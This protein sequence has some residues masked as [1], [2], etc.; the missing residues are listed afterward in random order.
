MALLR[1]WIRLATPAL[2]GFVIGVVLY[3]LFTGR[4]QWGYL[5]GAMI[6]VAI[7]LLITVLRSGR[8]KP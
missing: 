2:A 8:D 3:G 7:M 1:Q 5:A 6:G 4:W